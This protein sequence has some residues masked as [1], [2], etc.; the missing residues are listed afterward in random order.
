MSHNLQETNL[1]DTW[2]RYVNA[3]NTTLR[4]EREALFTNTLAID[5][6]YTDPQIQTKGHDE[7]AQYMEQF[8]QQFPGCRFKTH[9]FLAHHR[10]SN[11]CSIARWHMVNDNDEIVSEGISYGVYNDEGLLTAETGFYETPEQ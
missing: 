4:S 1:R 10:C 7:L 2:E 6:C 8:H 3:W 5:S 11:R 9:Y